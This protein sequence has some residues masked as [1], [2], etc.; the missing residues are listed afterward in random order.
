MADERGRSVLELI[1]PEHPA[2]VPTLAE[3]NYLAAYRMIEARRM[4]QHG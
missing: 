4:K 2:A 1:A 3:R